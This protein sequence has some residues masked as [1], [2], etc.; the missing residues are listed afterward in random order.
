MEKTEKDKI[1]N[2]I[3]GVMH[4]EINSTLMKLGMIKDIKIEK[5]VKL[6]LVL[7]FLNVPIKDDL[8]DSIKSAI[9][10]INKNIEIKIN[11]SV[12]D[13]KE[14]E[15]FFSMARAAWIG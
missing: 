9:K 1:K 6:T 13:E 14:K 5:D 2:A 15:R 11:F 10:N 7:P 8:V 4:P 12:M 3:E